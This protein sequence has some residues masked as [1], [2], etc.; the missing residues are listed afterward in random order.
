MGMMGRILRQCRKPTGWLGRLVAR[1]MNISHS[2]LT[3]W[4]LSHV[5]VGEHSTILDIGCGGGGTIRKLAEIATEG[6]VYGIDYSEESVRIS[7]KLNRKLIEA[8]RAKVQHGSV[9]TMPFLDNMF[10]LVSAVETHYFCPNLVN[11]M[12][13]VLR[14]LKPGGILIVIGGE[15]KGGKCDER[16]ARW[17]EL[18]DMAYHTTDE[19]R[20]LLSAAG[21]SEVEVFEDYDRG[22]ICTVARKPTQFLDEQG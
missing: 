12:K 2:K 4:G 19:L 21:Y 13:K 20:E 11:D 17:A 22:W 6:K 9:S 3:D 15:Y 14:V 7:Q 5:S 8:G 18:G 16:N 10:D 1:G